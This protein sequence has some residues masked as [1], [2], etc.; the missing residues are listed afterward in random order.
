MLLLH[1]SSSTISPV[2]HLISGL[3][4]WPAVWRL[5]RSSY[6]QPEQEQELAR[7]R[8]HF[9]MPGHTPPQLVLQV[10]RTAFLVLFSSI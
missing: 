4:I 8:A 2:A 6:L 9:V 3:H 5:F 7:R 1:T 10:G